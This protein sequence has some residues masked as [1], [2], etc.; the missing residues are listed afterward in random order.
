[1]SST[2][3]ASTAP[4]TIVATPPASGAGHDGSS[5]GRI[6]DAAVFVLSIAAALAFWELISRSGAISQNDLPAM[7]TTIDQLWS[8]MQTGHFWAAF[9]YTVR[10]GRSAWHWRRCWPSRSASR[11]G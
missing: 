11:S 6:A 7:T 2:S 10:G 8:Q 3:H 4:D 5:T 1:M 9:G